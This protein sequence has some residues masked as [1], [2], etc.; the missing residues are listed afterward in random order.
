[1]TSIEIASRIEAELKIKGIKKSVFYEKCG[2]SRA[3]FSQWKNGIHYPTREALG[4]VNEFLGLAFSVTEGELGQKEK[5][6]ATEGGELKAEFIR[7]FELLSPEAQE[8]EVA[9]LR[10][11]TS[12]KDN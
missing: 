2:I 11:Q 6:P 12:G 8:R 5:P 7:L 3:S 1:M 9:Y 4:R 10:A